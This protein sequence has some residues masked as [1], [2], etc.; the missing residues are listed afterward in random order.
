MLLLIIIF[1][2]CLGIVFLYCIFCATIGITAK[3][4]YL[5]ETIVKYFIEY[6]LY[7]KDINLFTAAILQK[8]DPVGFKE[9]LKKENIRLEQQIERLE[10]EIK[11]V[12]DIK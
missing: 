3:T 5:Q 8:L 2:L 11:K 4:E 9:L 7:Y 6:K 10:E 1:I 12:K